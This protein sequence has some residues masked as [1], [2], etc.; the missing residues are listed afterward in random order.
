MEQN[1]INFRWYVVVEPS[2]SKTFYGK[3]CL[4]SDEWNPEA[5]ASS[6]FS[7]KEHLNFYDLNEFISNFWDWLNNIKEIHVFISDNLCLIGNR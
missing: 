6:S 1:R 4:I 5:L 3:T 2:L 7:R